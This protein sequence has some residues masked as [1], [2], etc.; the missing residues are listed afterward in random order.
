ML[1]RGKVLGYMPNGD[2]GTG[3]VGNQE[4]FLVNFSTRWSS[5]LSE[6]FPFLPKHSR[7]AFPESCLQGKGKGPLHANPTWSN[8]I[9]QKR[10]PQH[11]TRDNPLYD[12]QKPGAHLPF[13][14]RRA[15]IRRFAFLK[16][17]DVKAG[18]LLMKST[19]KKWAMQDLK[20]VDAQENVQRRTMYFVPTSVVRSDLVPFAYMKKAVKNFHPL[21]PAEG[22]NRERTYELKLDTLND[23]ELTHWEKFFR[24]TFPT[25]YTVPIKPQGQKELLMEVNSVNER[26]PPAKTNNKLHY[27]TKIL[28][29][30]GVSDCFCRGMYQG[31]S[32]TGELPVAELQTITAEDEAEGAEM[33]GAASALGWDTMFLRSHFA[34]E[35]SLVSI[36]VSV[37]N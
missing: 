34:G 13:D 37:G 31:C 27:S 16:Q 22:G 21:C 26:V 24:A 2:A 1:L 14:F 35:A 10:I 18:G 6:K 20:N 4:T 28:M 23:D 17:V 11:S 19:S 29:N 7:M 5:I 25:K 32:S 33:A 15:A 30:E 9:P 3:L 12:D 8:N 36:A